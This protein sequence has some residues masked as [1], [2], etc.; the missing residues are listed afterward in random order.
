MIALLT[1]ARKAT[2]SAAIAFLSPPTA[3]LL[4]DQELSWRLLLASFLLGVVGGLTTY[5][6]A[7]TEP[8]VEQG[9]HH[10]AGQV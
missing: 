10:A 3:L 7:N 9:K 1:T 2:V 6:T 4:S 5:E 8:F